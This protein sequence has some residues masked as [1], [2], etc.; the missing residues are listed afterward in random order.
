MKTALVIS[1]LTL[2][3]AASAQKLQATTPPRTYVAGIA[4]VVRYRIPADTLVKPSGFNI[5]PHENATVVG[6]F[7]PR[8]LIVKRDGFLCLAS[9]LQL[10]DRTSPSK[11]PQLLDG[12]TR[13]FD[14]ATH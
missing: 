11:A 14:E 1:I 12:R 4:K 6:E 7:S 8:W 3:L 9:S 2:P 10:I 13:P 5:Q